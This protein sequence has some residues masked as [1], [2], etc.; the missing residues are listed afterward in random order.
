MSNEPVN[1][2]MLEAIYT[3]TTLH[4]RDQQFGSSPRTVG[5]F[6]DLETATQCILQNWGDI[7]ETSY[8]HAVIERVTPGLYAIDD[9]QEKWF[10]WQDGRYV[11]S[12]KP[13]RL[14]GTVF[15]SMG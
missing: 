11:A 4:F 3:V 7:N 2:T 5:W 12:E 1:D 6:V 8:D 15:F 9:R 14:I 10:E 13:E